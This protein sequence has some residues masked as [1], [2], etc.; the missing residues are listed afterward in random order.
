VES[1]PAVSN[2]RVYI[3]SDDRKLYAFGLK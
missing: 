2:G 1:S 3:G